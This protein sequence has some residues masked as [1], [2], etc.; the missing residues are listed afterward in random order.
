MARWAH[1]LKLNLNWIEA[2]GLEE[3]GRA[4]EEQLQDYDGLLVP[5]GVPRSR[6]AASFMIE[7][8]ESQLR[9]RFHDLTKEYARRRAGAS[10]PGD[11]GAMATQVYDALLTL[12]RRAHMAL[13]GGDAEVVHSS[14]PD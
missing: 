12:T 13:Y 6:L 2:E 4:A 5:G 3:G 9:Y 14:V 7:P 11:L 1:N 8:V 10:I